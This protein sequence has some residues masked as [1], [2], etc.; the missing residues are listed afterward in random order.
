[1]AEEPKVNMLREI[2]L[3]FDLMVATVFEG[4]CLPGKAARLLHERYGSPRL[5][6]T[7]TAVALPA[8]FG[9]VALGVE[10][11]FWEA[12]V[13][14]EVIR[15]Y[16]LLAAA[17]GAGV[18]AAWRSVI[19]QK[20]ANTAEQGQITDRYSKAVEMLS[21]EKARTRVGAVY[22]LDRI[23]QDSVVRDHIPV[24]EVLGEFLRNPPYNT[25]TNERAITLLDQPKTAESAKGAST[26]AEPAPIQC[27]DVHAA[28]DAIGAR[29]QAQ[30]AH[31]KRIGFTLSLERAKIRNLDLERANLADLNLSRAD[32]SD[33]RLLFANLNGANLNGAS[34]LGA[35]LSGANLNGADL[36]GADLSG[37]NLRGRDLRGVDL[38]G[39][40]LRAADLSDA[41]LRGV[42]LSGARLF[43]AELSR[44]NLDGADLTDA[45]LDGADLTDANLR[46]VK[47]VGVD[48]RDTKLDEE[49]L[50]YTN[51]S[52]ANLGGMDLEGADLGDAN[53]EN[54]RF[55]DA[56]LSGA[57]L[58][59]V[60][61]NGAY[62]RGSDLRRA[63]L[64]GANL[65]GADLGSANLGVTN[66]ERADLAGADL[67]NVTDLKQSQI[68]DCL[69]ACPPKNL[70]DDLIWP[71]VERDGKWVKGE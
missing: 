49:N 30:I 20:Q 26:D 40:K 42:D 32:L 17:F 13:Q 64:A 18:L 52:A 2:V 60:N 12:K 71:F 51:L 67:T 43:G 16:G 1:M 36:S 68:D 28:L 58:R 21:D 62:L 27:P 35:D 4:I 34:L 70:R 41:N 59:G 24:M 47:L 11:A 25:E 29:N 31:E 23:A 19:N 66:F 15:N 14:S 6:W 37:A 69:P 7:V 48:L 44:A 10:S 50:R 5:Y 61:L 45:N 54:A 57:K 9:Y 33:A 3:G 38:S 22:A 53:L 46:Y 56:N 8:A 63:D 55:G 65:V 39:A